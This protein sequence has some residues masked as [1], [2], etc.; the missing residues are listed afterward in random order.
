VLDRAADL[1]R[2]VRS[3]FTHMTTGRP[4][5]A[6]VGVPFDVQI[7]VVDE[8]EVWADRTLG[9]FPSRRVGPD[10]QAVS[11]AAEL[12]AAVQRPGFVC[13]GGVVISNAE[14]EL[15]ALAERVGAAVATTSSGRGSLSD[16]PPLP[17]G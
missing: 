10:P 17:G 12:I 15:Q 8:E 7:D 2:V 13:G 4:G 6:H 3:A 5:A 14:A 1:P 9:Q 11:I 16:D